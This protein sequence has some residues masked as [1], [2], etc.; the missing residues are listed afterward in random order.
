MWIIIDK[1]YT[2]NPR[3]KAPQNLS[4]ERFAAST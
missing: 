3:I 4:R 1:V 2:E